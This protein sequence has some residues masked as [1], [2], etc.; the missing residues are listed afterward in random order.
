MHVHRPGQRLVAARAELSAGHEDH[1]LRLRQGLHLLRVEQVGRDRLDTP[2]FKLSTERGFA[3]PGNADH[4]LLR[5]GAAGKARQRRSHLA[6][7]AEDQDVAIYR[8]EVVY[9]CLG[10][11]GQEIVEMID[12][13]EAGR[14]A[15]SR[16]RIG[17]ICGWARRIL[18]SYSSPSVMRWPTLARF[19][20]CFN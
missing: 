5:R 2:A 9:Q 11:F 18:H 15:S 6:A 12:V 17:S 19:D 1:V 14:Q 8:G 4:P 10:R 16:S 7:D 20:S 13:L 3:E